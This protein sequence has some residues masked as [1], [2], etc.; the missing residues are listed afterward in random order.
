MKFSIV[1][2]NLNYGDFLECCLKS[3]EDQEG[4]DLDVFIVD[5]GS[6][7]NSLDVIKDYC[8][9]NGWAWE[10]K[11]GLGQAQSI[12]YGFER[13]RGEDSDIMGW[14][15]SDDT[16]IRRDSLKIVAEY[17]N[18]LNNV[19]M[20]ALG[21]FYLNAR[22]VLMKPIVYDYSPLIKG[23]IFLRGGAFI[24]PAT[25]WRRFVYNDVGIRSKYRYVFDGD[26]F[27]RVRQSQYNIYYD[28]RRHIVGYR[29]HGANLSLN[30]PSVRLS[31]L[32]DLYESVLHRRFSAIYLKGLYY[33]FRAIERVPFL[34]IHVKRIV[35]VLNNLMSYAT[36]YMIPSI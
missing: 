10:L 5:G 2:P 1:V 26:Y 18:Y 27:N 7:D 25:F 20:I 8:Q 36:R 22:G 33:F 28:Q 15:N 9:R 29:L 31:E 17:F 16:Y 14:L 12:T 24:Q 11:S 34:D 21:G 23:D 13:L 3:L 4:I 30:Y 19:D 35:Y 32:S 6:S